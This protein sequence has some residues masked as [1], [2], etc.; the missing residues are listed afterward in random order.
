MN[1]SRVR[2]LVPVEVDTDE[3]EEPAPEERTRCKAGRPNSATLLVKV[4]EILPSSSCTIHYSACECNLASASHQCVVVDPHT[5]MKEKRQETTSLALSNSV[6]DRNKGCCGR[7]HVQFIPRTF[8][9][10]AAVWL[11]FA[12]KWWLHNLFLLNL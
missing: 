5:K 4:V 8:H 3:T 12:R 1:V 10:P 6:N 2:G 7:F 9:C 11:S